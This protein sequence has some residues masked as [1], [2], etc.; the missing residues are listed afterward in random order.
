MNLSFKKSMSFLIMWLLSLGF[1]ALTNVVYASSTLPEI[2]DGKIILTEDVKLTEKYV[3]GDG[4][5]ITIDLAGHT[6]QGPSD[7]YAIDN[8]GDLTIVDSSDSKGKIVCRAE[9]ASCVRNFNTMN[10]NG[11]TIDSHFIAVK[12][13]PKC[14][15]KIEE[16]TISA[17]TETGLLN[18]GNATINT[19]KISTESTR[20][21]AVYITSG[22]L[23]GSTSS[24]D[25]S[26]STLEG[27]YVIDYDKTKKLTKDLNITDT[28]LQGGVPTK[29]LLSLQ[30]LNVTVDGD[31]TVGADG[32]VFFTKHGENGATITLTEDAKKTINIPEGVTLIVPEGVTLDVASTLTSKGNLEVYGTLKNAN[33]YNETTK[34]YYRA[35]SSAISSAKTGNKIVLQNDVSTTG[36]KTKANV[37][38]TLELNGKTVTGDITNIAGGKLTIKDSSVSKTGKVNGL[39][40]NNGVLNIEGGKY[41]VTPVTSEN[42]ETTLTGGIYPVQ[43]VNDANVPTNME[44]L[45]NGD[46]TYSLVYKKADYSAVKDALTKAENI[47]RSLYTEESL[48]KL[49]EA[50]NA[51]VEGKKIDEQAEVDAMATVIL[52]AIDELIIITIP[53]TADHIMI[54]VTLGLIS[55]IVLAAIYY[56]RKKL[57]N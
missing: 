44:L 15:L 51:V 55:L 46:G 16:S 48:K 37:D 32:V 13:E 20:T 21:G 45:D 7:N 34:V 17:V 2:G 49:D 29:M 40:T 43:D 31:N 9:S 18:A 23:A 35:L 39:V 22:T 50:I 56:N 11:V 30:K 47:D 54:Y 33:A 12:S 3:V 25:I 57:F 41:T 28:K 14:T 19:S 4:E 52:S 6:L 24:L 1:F 5:T 53:D 36:I 10:I 38:I 26:S 27:K 8:L 42:A